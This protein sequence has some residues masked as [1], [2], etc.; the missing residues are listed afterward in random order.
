MCLC[1][2]FTRSSRKSRLKKLK[3]KIKTGVW[4]L[5]GLMQ[6]SHFFVLSNWTLLSRW[7]G[8]DG[9]GGGGDGWWF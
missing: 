5:P 6:V 1:C 2:A 7:V 3:K 9:G 8:D 4:F